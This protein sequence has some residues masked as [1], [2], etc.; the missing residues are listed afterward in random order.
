MKKTWGIV[1]ML[2]VVSPFAAAQKIRPADDPDVASSLNLLASWIAARIEYKN[3]PGLSVG[4]IYDQEL[5][6]AKGF[7]WAD[8]ENKT[9]AAP[10]TIYRVG[11]INKLFTA[12][13]VMRSFADRG[14]LRLDDPA[15]KFLP[16][17]SGFDR[18]L[19]QAPL[20]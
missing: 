15:V 16:R 4:I 13:A 20:E 19:S 5:I 9:A 11:S 2:V 1:L 7:G 10:R 6:W 3:D 18:A 17:P 12:T 14:K 8:L